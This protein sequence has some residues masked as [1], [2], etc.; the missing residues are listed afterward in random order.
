MKIL[1]AVDGSEFS[2]AAVQKACET[3][4][5]PGGEV[6]IISV[7]EDFASAASE[8]FTV[9]A[10]YIREMDKGMRE[11]AQAAAAEAEENIRECFGT[12]IKIST[13]IS[14]GAAARAIVEEAED[15]DADLIIVGSHGYGFWGRAFLG[16][17]SQAVINQAPCS[18]LIVR[19][20]GK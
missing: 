4:A 20:K 18:V 12:D 16:S 1:I 8:P 7:Y 11:Q 13:K 6:K 3:I 19:N 9:S 5:K 14:K 15:W 2:Q 17:V 10:E